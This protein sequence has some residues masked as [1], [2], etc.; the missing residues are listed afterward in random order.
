MGTPSMNALLTHPRSGASWA[1]FAL[2]QVLRVAAPDEAFFWASHNGA[3]LDLLLFKIGR[4]I[5]VEFKRADAPR[6]TPSMTIAR[7]DLQLERRYVVYPG[8]QRY[9]KDKRIEAVPLAARV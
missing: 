2:E 1:G 4:R 8:T 7:H 3:E 5:G 6:D 9:T